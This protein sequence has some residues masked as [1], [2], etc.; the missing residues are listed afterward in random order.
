MTLKTRKLSP[1]ERRISQ[2]TS[3]SYIRGRLSEYRFLQAYQSHQLQESSNHGKFLQVI[4]SEYIYVQY[5][6]RHAA[7]FLL[8]NKRKHL[9]TIQLDC[10][11][12]ICRP[13]ICWIVV[14]N[15]DR[16]NTYQLIR[17]FRL[18]S[19]IFNPHIE[20]K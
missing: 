1:S 9:L 12:L 19:D 8:R 17:L 10:S 4:G 14:M 13:L 16:I 18:S 11:V 5:T 20:R 7:G 15:Q 2:I 6:V 3:D